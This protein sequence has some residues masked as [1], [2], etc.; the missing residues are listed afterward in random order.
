MCSYSSCCFKR[1]TQ[2]GRGNFGVR[3]EIGIRWEKTARHTISAQRV[4]ERKAQRILGLV[5]SKKLEACISQMPKLA[6][7][8]QIR[9]FRRPHLP[10]IGYRLKKVCLNDGLLHWVQTQDFPARVD[11]QISLRCSGS[12]FQKL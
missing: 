9:R 1:G 2:F 5:A 3:R 6:R 8:K 12:R 10:Q 4:A 7:R 11:S